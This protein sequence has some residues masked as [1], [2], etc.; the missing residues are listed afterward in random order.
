MQAS[1]INLDFSLGKEMFNFLAP[2]EE[3]EVVRTWERHTTLTAATSTELSQF[4]LLGRTW[5]CFPPQNIMLSYS[6]I[7]HNTQTNR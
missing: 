6:I 7:H 1:S 4:C 3:K 2:F 5:N